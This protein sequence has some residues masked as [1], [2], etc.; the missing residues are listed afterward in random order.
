MS[1][2]LRPAQPLS[3]AGST[4]LAAVRRAD[5]DW[6]RL[7]AFGLLI[8]YHAGMPFA[9]WD[10]HVKDVH[11]SEALQAVMLFMN[12]WRMPLV[13]FVSGAAIMLALGRRTPGEFLRDRVKRLLVPLAFGMAAIV[14]PQVWFERVQ[15]GQFAGSYFEFLPHAFDGVYPAGNLSWHH[16]WFLAYVLLLTLALM[17]LWLWLRSPGGARRLDALAEAVTH[18]R[19]LLWSPVPAIALVEFVLR[20]L[21]SN[22]N[23]LVGDWI[24][25]ARYGLLLALGA[26]AFSRPQIVAAIAAHRRTALA[27][28][29]LAF[30][31]LFLVYFSRGLRPMADPLHWPLFC[32]LSAVNLWAWVLGLSGL[33]VR[34]LGGVRPAWLAAA[35]EA[36]FPFY[37]LHQTLI[38]A[39]AFALAPLASPVAIKLVLVVAATFAGCA[40]LYGLIR[41]SRIVQPLFGMKPAVAHAK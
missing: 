8:L 24:G 20:P 29:A 7:I 32:A 21:S 2:A 11:R 25:L 35:T 5:V 27:C 40:L 38:V 19:L 9:A 26:L 12:R 14:P 13:F 36:V 3:T 17:P 6:L 39:F 22:P 41:R 37:I 16:L 30:A 1:L 4:P 31:S 15:R 34:H 28:G 23:G 10:W 33:V 18:R